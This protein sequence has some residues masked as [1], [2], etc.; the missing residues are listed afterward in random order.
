MNELVVSPMIQQ[1]T[2]TCINHALKV[3]LS[4]FIGLF[5]IFSHYIP[6]IQGI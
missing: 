1:Q 5:M 6:G 4:E 3:E 2:L